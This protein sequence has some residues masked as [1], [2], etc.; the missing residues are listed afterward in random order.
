MADHL[1]PEARSANMRAVRRRDTA[2]EMRVRRLLHRLGYRYRLQAGDLPGKPDIVFRGRRVAVFVHGCFW[3]GHECRRGRLPASRVDYWRS[4]IERN[5]NRD[6][7]AL[8]ALQALGWRSLVIWEC[9]IRDLVA[10]EARLRGF[11][12]PQGRLGR[13]A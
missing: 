1:T 9:E 4:R 3:H 6:E 12:G 13:P 11:L 2:P 8:R 5:R 7:R 10:L